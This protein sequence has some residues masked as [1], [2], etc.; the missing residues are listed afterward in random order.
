MKLLKILLIVPAAIL[1]VIILILEKITEY[2]KFFFETLY[3]FIEN[4]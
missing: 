4:E 2:L 1:F 3:R